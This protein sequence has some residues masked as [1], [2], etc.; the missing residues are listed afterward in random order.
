MYRPYIKFLILTQII[1]FK[2]IY[3]ADLIFAYTCFV[4]KL[5]LR[6][7][8]WIVLVDISQCTVSIPRKLYTCTNL[9]H[10]KLS[11]KKKNRD[12]GFMH[13]K[14]YAMKFSFLSQRISQI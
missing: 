11:K 10:G 3:L 7:I 8:W 14:Y 9:E 13:W 2:L 1:S 6:L 12:L 4:P 5:K